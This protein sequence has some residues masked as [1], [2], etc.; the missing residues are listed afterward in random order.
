MPEVA[1]DPR[2]TQRFRRSRIQDDSL[3][4]LRNMLKWQVRWLQRTLSQCLSNLING[5]TR[6][7]TTLAK[8]FPESLLSEVC[9][10][11]SITWGRELSIV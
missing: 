7:L 4:S 10:C 8:C 9:I 1:R 5:L 3:P 2:A 11:Q 6:E